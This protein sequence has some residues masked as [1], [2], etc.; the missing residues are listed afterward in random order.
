[1]FHL[2]YFGY[3]N[4]GNMADNSFENIL[5]ELK[6][7]ATETVKGNYVIREI[8]L[9][10]Q[11]KI[12][13]GGFE[14]VEMPAKLA[15]IYNDYIRESVVRNDSMV[16]ISQVVTVDIKPYLLIELR[17]NTFGDI[18]YGD[19]DEDEEVENKEYKLYEVT[20][21]DLESAIKP[22]KVKFGNVT[23][24]LDV[25]TIEKESKYNSLLISTGL[26][27]FKKKKIDESTLAQVADVYQLY[28]MMKYISTI[29]FDGVEYDFDKVAMAQKMRFLDMISPTIVNNINKFIKKVKKS[30]EKA[31]K[32]I[33]D[34]GDEIT[35]GT[36]N[37]FMNNAKD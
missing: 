22:V 37:L 36:R 6:N 26:S 20:A 31:F 34:D 11:R 23:I 21:K 7:S 2:F 30:E 17:K 3:V 15:N 29:V 13:N 14:A 9:K 10:Q 19:G 5:A 25:P 18:Y 8:T 35:L 32:A 24:K 4:K 28:E 12:L 27:S 33:A 16:D 1:M